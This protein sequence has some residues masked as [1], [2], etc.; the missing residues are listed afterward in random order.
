MTRIRTG[1]LQIKCRV[2]SHIFKMLKRTVISCDFQRGIGAEVVKCPVNTYVTY[3]KAFRFIN[4]LKS[5]LF[6]DG[7]RP[8]TGDHKREYTMLFSTL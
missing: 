8:H 5:T 1:Q 6:T 7:F 2:V 4:T 3:L